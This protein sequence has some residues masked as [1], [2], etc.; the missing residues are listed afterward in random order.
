M[1]TGLSAPLK[2]DKQGRM[3]LTSSDEHLRELLGIA[4]GQGQSDNPFQDPGVNPEDIIFDLDDPS[5]FTIITDRIQRA[6]DE[7]EAEE[8]ATLDEKSDNLV[9][10][11]RTESGFKIAVFYVN[12]ET[13]QPNEL[14]VVVGD[15]GVRVIRG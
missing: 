1:P 4:L 8:L 13:G 3:K 10:R 15:Q 12:L 9:I 6:F 5:T 7:F 14:G 11:Q 2:A